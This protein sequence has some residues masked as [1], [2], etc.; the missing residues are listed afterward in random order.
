[1]HL[2]GWARENK[3]SR[4]LAWDRIE[5]P[6]RV[7]CKHCW[8]FP[9]PESQ[10]DLTLGRRETHGLPSGWSFLPWVPSCLLTCV[11]FVWIFLHQIPNEVFC[12]SER[13]HKGRNQSV[14]WAMIPA[15]SE[16]VMCSMEMMRPALHRPYSTLGTGT[17]VWGKEKP[18]FG[19]L[20]GDL[21]ER[22]PGQG[23]AVPFQ[24]QSLPS[25]S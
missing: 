8:A 4:V 2:G 14:D 20:N 19:T 17:S 16:S 11:S 24:L 10:Q 9:G 22:Q 21:P 7:T 12:C 6:G 25:G 1:M 18:R 3:R 13:K 15:V 5:A 23:W